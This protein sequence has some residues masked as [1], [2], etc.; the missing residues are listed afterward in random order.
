MSLSLCVLASGSSGNCSGLRSAGA[1]MLIDC[2]I[3][4]RTVAGR[5]KGTGVDVRDVAAI[6][7]THL[8]RDHFSFNWIDTIVRQ[9][10]RVFCSADRVDELNR[11]VDDPAFAQ[12]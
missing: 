6:C 4:P 8:D 1:V 3:G 5:L 7:L 9:Q 10:I 12:R 2:G 11:L